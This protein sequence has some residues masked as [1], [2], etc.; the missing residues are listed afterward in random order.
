MP[1]D[2]GGIVA[3]PVVGE[4]RGYRWWRLTGS[5]LTS[6]WRGD[7]RWGRHDNV[8]S[9]LGRRWLLRWKPHGVP[10]DRGIPETDCSCGFYAMLRA[11]VEG[12]DG[13]GCWPLNPSLSGGPIALVF[14]VVRGCGRVVLGQYGWR[15]ERAQVDALYV[16]VSR[17]PTD[18]LVAVSQ[19]YGAPIYRDL[20][21]MCEERGPDDWTMDL[22][23]SAA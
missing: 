16:P 12:V 4:V 20:D 8:A 6:P 15:A 2:A 10:H 7:I 3:E 9:C 22:A 17:T 21:A 14:G 13:P 19:S 11:P 1:F 5:W 23:T 18:G